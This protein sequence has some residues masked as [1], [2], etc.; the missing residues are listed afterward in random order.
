MFLGNVICGL[1]STKSL[2]LPMFT[3]LRRFSILFTMIGEW[4][5]L[6]SKPSA[7]VVFSIFMMVGG[8][9]LAAV[10]DLSYDTSG[11]TLVFC[12][13]VFTTLN[14][15]WMKKA[16]L[17]G[18]CSKM[19]VLFYNSLFSAVFMCAYFLVEH[20]CISYHVDPTLSGEVVSNLFASS[21]AAIAETTPSRHLA[22][23]VASSALL[24]AATSSAGA[25]A[26]GSL[27]AQQVVSAAGAVAVEV[28]RESTLTSVFKFELLADWRFLVM[29]VLAASM[30]SILNYSIFVCTTVN[31]AL[32][33]AVVGALKNVATTY[34]GMMVF[35]DYSFSWVNFF[36]INI[37]IAGSLYYTYITIFK[38]ATGFGGG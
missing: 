36:G 27:P 7:G 34:I 15:V 23:A 33:T 30:G 13:N 35:A 29:F 26:A 10:Y 28:L 37:S 11:Y 18:K 4:C 14:G 6:N 3:A 24:N 38:G 9:L 20:L 31:S 8:A 32:T 22:V 1:G 25:L 17:S 16:S 2:N 19:G 12:N 21:A 5:F